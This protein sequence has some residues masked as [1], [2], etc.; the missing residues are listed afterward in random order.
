MPR[1][2]LL[3]TV[4]AVLFGILHD[5]VTARVCLEYFTVAHARLI[6]SESPT[7]VGLVWG[8]AATW[9]AGLAVGLWLAATAQEGDAP[10]LT[11]RDFVRPAAYLFGAM[12]AA[13][14]LGGTLGY[15]L[16]QR[17]AISI[18]PEFASRVPAVRQAL[19]MADVWAHISAYAAGFAGTV[20]VDRWVRRRRS[21][22]RRGPLTG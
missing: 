12:A 10:R 21:Q 14:A 15:V 20:V 17:G 4:G 3:F 2:V 18:G 7:L 1:I 11:A 13:S 8:V 5:Q 22:L 9:W 16:A 19:F 6:V